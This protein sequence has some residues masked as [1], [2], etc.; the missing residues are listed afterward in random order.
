MGGQNL[1]DVARILSEHGECAPQAIITAKNAS[2]PAL[3]L[4]NG[5][6]RSLPVSEGTV[7]C[8]TIEAGDLDIFSENYP[9]FQYN[10]ALVPAYC[11][12]P[13]HPHADR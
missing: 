7:F 6:A 10:A 2:H 1:P 4:Q 8:T 3:T 5:V 11:K 13:M 12:D 9:Y